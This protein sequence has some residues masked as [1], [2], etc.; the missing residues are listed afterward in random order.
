MEPLAPDP[1]ALIPPAPDWQTNAA[2]LGMDVNLFFPDK[3][4]STAPAVEVCERCPVRVECFD[5]AIAEG[6]TMGVF[7]GVSPK[8][9]R[10]LLETTREQRARHAA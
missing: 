4:G 1:A 5:W 9:R 2:C 3:G 8:R 10:P 7:G 6:F